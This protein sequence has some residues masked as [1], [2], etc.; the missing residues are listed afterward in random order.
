M[1]RLDPIGASDGLLQHFAIG[2]IELDF[3]A[4]LEGD[5]G[6]AFGRANIDALDIA[7]FRDLS[8]IA[9]L[10]LY[11]HGGKVDGGRF[12]GAALLFWLD[13]GPL[14][15]DLEQDAGGKNDGQWQR[16]GEGEPVVNLANPA[17]H[18]KKVAREND[19]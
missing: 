3:P 10:Q 2:E 13:P 7:P 6:D 15:F 1:D 8:L 9:G 14:L 17:V 19:G 12:G 4:I 5:F 16:D 18:D 11:Q